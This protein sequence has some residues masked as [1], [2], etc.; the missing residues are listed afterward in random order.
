MQLLLPDS[1]STGSGAMK[2]PNIAGIIATN[3]NQTLI[4][5]K[6]G[7]QITEIGSLWDYRNGVEIFVSGCTSSSQQ[8]FKDSSI[9]KHG[10]F[11][12]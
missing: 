1:A 7:L 2:V 9:N 6:Y 4:G 5:Q 8:V 3:G 10:A 11:S 12:S